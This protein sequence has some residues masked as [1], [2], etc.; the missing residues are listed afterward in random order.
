MKKL[1]QSSFIIYL[2]VIASYYINIVIANNYSVEVVADYFFYISLALVFNAILDFNFESIGLIYSGNKKIDVYIIQTLLIQFKLAVALIIIALSSITNVGFSSDQAALFMMIAFYVPVIY[3]KESKWSEYALI[4]LLE[5]LCFLS[6]VLVSYTIIQ[7]KDFLFYAYFLSTFISSIFQLKSFSQKN[8]KY[9]LLKNFDLLVDYIKAAFPLYIVSLIMLMYGHFS[10]WFVKSNFGSMEFA[11]FSLAMTFVNLYSI[12]QRQIEKMVR[13][14][15]VLNDTISEKDIIK[16]YFKHYVPSIFAIC[17]LMI[18]FSENIVSLLFDEKWQGLENV[19]SIVILFI[20]PVSV[21]RFLDLLAA[22][23]SHSMINLKVGLL[24]FLIFLI[25]SLLY[26][27]ELGFHWYL[28][29]LICLQFIHS[30][31]LYKKLILR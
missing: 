19:I 7:L 12:F 4:L 22:S 3:E 24:F 2:G 26:I 8:I 13:Y 18:F 10:R 30:I 21:L 23:R 1:I 28:L 31:T 29:S 5:R 14:N 11:S 9:S 25:I 20:I 6:F 27:N 16:S 15:I 17:I